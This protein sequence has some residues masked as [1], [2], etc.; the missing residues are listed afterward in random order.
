[1]DP[2]NEEAAAVLP[3]PLHLL[4]RKPEACAS[5][6]EQKAQSAFSSLILLDYKLSAAMSLS[7]LRLRT[8]KRLRG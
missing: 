3:Q 2:S 5:A 4:K 7:T 6:L 8:A 1:M